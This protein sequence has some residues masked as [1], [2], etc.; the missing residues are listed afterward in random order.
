MNLLTIGLTVSP[1]QPERHLHHSRKVVGGLFGDDSARARH[2]CARAVEYVEE[3]HVEAQPCPFTYREL[4]KQRCIHVPLVGTGEM[5]IAG[6]RIP[7]VL[8]PGQAD[9]CATQLVARSPRKARTAGSQS[10][11]GLTRQVPADL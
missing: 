5:L 11:V 1:R 4:L 7:N 2:G 10:L 6:L 8:R 3:I 9:F